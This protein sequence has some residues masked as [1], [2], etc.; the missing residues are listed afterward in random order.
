MNPEVIVTNLKKRYTGVSGT[1]NAL[2]P[3]Q[4]KTL[5]T[6][7]VGTDLPGARSAQ[8]Q[9]PDNFAHL[10]L[11]QAIWASRKRLPDGRERIWHVRRDPEML[12]AI[13][14]ICV[15]HAIETYILNPQ[16]YGHHMHM[17]PVLVLIIL[18]QVALMLIT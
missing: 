12:L 18:L 10:S 17:N 13:L 3:V 11:W 7:F 5:K 2:L 8:Q 9:S 16:I 4:A 14:L 1:I 6:G 15:I